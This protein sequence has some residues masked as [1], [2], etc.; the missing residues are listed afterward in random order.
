[1]HN[2]KIFQ[3]DERLKT[4]EKHKYNLLVRITFFK[5]SNVDFF[6]TFIFINYF[7]K[8]DRKLKIYGF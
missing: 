6:G 4:L 2:N 1:M 5:I 3:K 8:Y 7:L